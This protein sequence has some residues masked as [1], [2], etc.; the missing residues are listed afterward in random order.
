[1][2]GAD[3][4]YR[5]DAKENWREWAWRWSARQTRNSASRGATKHCLVLYLPG[6]EDLDRPHALRMGFKPHNLIGV[7]RNLDVVKKNRALGVNMIHGELSEVLCSWSRSPYPDV[8]MADLCTGMTQSTEKLAYGLFDIENSRLFQAAQ[9]RQKSMKRAWGGK[10]CTLTV[11]I[12]LLRGRDSDSNSFRHLK[13]GPEKHRGL[14]FLSWASEMYSFQM[15]NDQTLRGYSGDG[16]FTDLLPQM[17]I[18]LNKSGFNSNRNVKQGRTV[19][20]FK[21]RIADTFETA[22]LYSYRSEISGQVF[23]SVC[24]SHGFTWL[25]IY[26]GRSA[27]IYSKLSQ[28]LSVTQSAKNRIAAA[29]S[30]RSTRATTSG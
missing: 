28:C 1:V 24:Y 22:K 15:L 21:S 13:L 29:K 18:D 23:D 30:I 6:P 17:Q 20:Y 27:E 14:A 16:S 8:V 3:K 25:S 10:P 11:C 19:D 26:E 9:S 5:F 12:N 7:D 2:S 4:D